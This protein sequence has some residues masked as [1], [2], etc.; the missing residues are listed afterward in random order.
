MALLAMQSGMAPALWPGG[1]P[2]VKRSLCASLAYRLS[3]VAAGRV[4]GMVTLRDAWEWD[5]AA[6]VP[7]AAR[8]GAVVTERMGAPIR[9]NAARPQAAGV[10]GAAPGLHGALMGGLVPPVE[11]PASGGWFASGGDP[12]NDPAI[13]PTELKRV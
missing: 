2:Q 10:V 12:G 11:Q 3:L 13:T 8:A 9:F 6:G 5:I 1:V 4:D 7:I